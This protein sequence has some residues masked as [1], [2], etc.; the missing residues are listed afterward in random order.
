MELDI[1]HWP[2]SQPEDH[3]DQ[4][5]PGAIGIDIGLL[6]ENL[7]LTA[8]QRIRR[9]DEMIRVLSILDGCGL[10]C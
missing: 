1:C 4:A 7:R 3:A 6:E 9:N 5:R 2:L 8:A 10:R